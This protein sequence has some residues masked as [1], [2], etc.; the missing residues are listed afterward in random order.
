MSRWRERQTSWAVRR[1][2][3]QS[4]FRRDRFI[5]QKLFSQSNR[6]YFLKSSVRADG[7]DLLRAKV[8]NFL[9]HQRFEGKAV[10]LALEH[11]SKQ[12]HKG[13]GEQG[14]GRAFFQWTFGKYS[15][16]R[17]FQSHALLPRREEGSAPFLVVDIYFEEYTVLVCYIPLTLAS[18]AA[19]PTSILLIRDVTK[20]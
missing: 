12:L 2:R 18:F 11:R 9:L 19:V 4:S 13:S 16:A 1:T 14:S 10:L 5:T 20:G 17:S 3:H 15:H 6:D 8:A 7:T